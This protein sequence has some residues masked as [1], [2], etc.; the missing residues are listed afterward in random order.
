MD[1]M[2]VLSLR[3]K[4]AVF[5]HE[6]ALFL[7]DMTDREPTWYSVTVKAG[8]NPSKLT[9][10]GIKVYNIKKELAWRDRSEN[11]LWPYRSCL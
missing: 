1:A 6:T 5:S 3:C 7:H 10:D 8:Y 2:Y 11:A 9:A 4:Q